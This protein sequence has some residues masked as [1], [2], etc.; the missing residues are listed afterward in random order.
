MQETFDIRD[1]SVFKAASGLHGGIGG[2]HGTCGA[3]LGA[4]MI[5]GYK[6]GLPEKEAKD[7][8]QEHPTKLVGQFYR[9]FEK[10][11]GSVECRTITA[12]FDNETID[13]EVSCKFS[14]QEK[15][16]R[17]RAKCA[18]LSGKTAAKAVEVLCKIPI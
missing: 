1:E 14:E 6:Y 18:D 2:M 15:L 8:N 10:E 4:C 17:R 13:Q 11:F 7:I 16:K 3:L 5:L 12:G 9:W